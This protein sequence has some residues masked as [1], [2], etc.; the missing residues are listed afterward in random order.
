[1]VGETSRATMEL[2]P[3][4]SLEVWDF[5][6]SLAQT[7]QNEAVFGVFF[8]NLVSVHLEVTDVSDPRESGGVDFRQPAPWLLGTYETPFRCFLLV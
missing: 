8:G 6:W 7:A 4:G 5:I 3:P 1:M 2:V